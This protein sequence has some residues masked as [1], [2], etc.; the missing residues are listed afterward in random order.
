MIKINCD[1]KLI[2]KL[3]NYSIESPLRK[4]RWRKII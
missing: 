1:S 2:S 4:F 3:I